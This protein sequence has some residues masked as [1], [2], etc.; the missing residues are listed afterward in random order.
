MKFQ[1]WYDNGTGYY[2]AGE[3]VEAASV[4]DAL[5]LAGG[6]ATPWGTRQVALPEGQ[7]PNQKEY[8]E[9]K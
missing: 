9:K 6:P 3:I 8:D 5:A 1:I 2:D 4:E 7:D